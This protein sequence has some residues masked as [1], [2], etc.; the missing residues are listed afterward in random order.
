MESAGRGVRQADSARVGGRCARS[1]GALAAAALLAL[2]LAPLAR[3][4]FPYVGDGTLAQP[5]SWALAPGH[6]PSNVGGLAWKY[7]AT[8]V[9][10]PAETSEP[11]EHLAVTRAVMPRAASRAH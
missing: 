5:S 2:T 11:A 4:D 9:T 10:P 6:V 7:A 8:P 3:A 1:L